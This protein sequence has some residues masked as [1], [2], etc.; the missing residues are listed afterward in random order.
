MSIN[1][2]ACLAA[3]QAMNANLQ[4]CGYIAGQSAAT[5]SSTC[6]CGTDSLAVYAQTI[7]ACPAD[8]APRASL[9]PLYNE[10]T[11][12]VDVS[13]ATV[14]MCATAR[15]ILNYSLTYC[16]VAVDASRPVPQMATANDLLQCLC[17]PTSV[18]HYKYAINQCGQNSS[19]NNIM[20]AN[21]LARFC[22][23]G[24][25]PDDLSSLLGDSGSGSGSGATGTAVTGRGA[26]ATATATVLAT[27]PASATAKSSGFSNSFSVFG[28]LATVA[29]LF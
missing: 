27:A 3:S 1:S 10:C 16:G 14:G 20:I 4:T 28:V 13:D 17:L 21:G 24:G 9:Q 15:D 2:A 25:S 6:L 7:S 18:S 11:L 22:A 12:P 8:S 26:T 19:F 23:K 5:Q 29:L